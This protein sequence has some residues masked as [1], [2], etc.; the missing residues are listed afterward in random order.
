LKP[1][2]A[3]KQPQTPTSWQ[4]MPAGQLIA[5]AIEHHLQPWW[6]RM[7]GY[8][9]LKIGS[10]SGEIA[11]N[12]AP[13]KHQVTVCDR[14]TSTSLTTGCSK[15]VADIDDLPLLKHSVD[16][17]LLCHA[18]EFAVDPHHVIREASRV[19]IPNG[20]LVIS[21]F[22][23]FSPAGLNKLIFFRRSKLPWSGRF[24]SP[25]RVKDW[26]HLMGYEIVEDKRFLPFLL[27]GRENSKFWWQQ[28]WQAF[29]QHY[30]PSCGSVYLI[31]AKKRK[32]PLTPIKPKWLV[33]PKFTPVNVTSMHSR[34]RL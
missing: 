34:K 15:L 23:P 14:E 6:Q 28:K 3:F 22:N 16:V 31:V 2:L 19:V 17:A 11:S 20:Y 25:M 4:Q 7:F 32:L 29:C 18:L 5:T 9:L 27:T 21:G 26:L 30:F 12:A 8:H 13:I 10:L 1:A 24:F 33:R